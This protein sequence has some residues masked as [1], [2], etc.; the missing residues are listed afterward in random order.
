[1]SDMLMIGSTATSAFRRALEVT[2]HNVANVSTEGYSRQRAE[3]VNNSA[4]IVGPVQ[5]GG[6]V[7]VDNVLRIQADYIQS[8]LVSSSST[9]SRYDESLQQSKQVEGLIAGNDEGVQQV[10]QQ[11][12]D[13]I[14]N[15]ASNPT[16]NVNRQLVVD[17][18]SKLESH[19]ENLTSVLISNEDDVNN[20]IDSMVLE[21]NARVDLVA[22]VNDEVGKTL[23]NGGQLPNDL[24]DQ[25]DQAILEL[26][27]LIDIKAHETENGSIDIYTA[28]GKFPLVSD[29]TV[30]RIDSRLSEF[31]NENRKEVY[32]TISGQSRD[33]GEFITGGTLGGILDFRSEMLDSAKN[34]LGVMLNGLVASTNWQNYQGYDVNGDAG[35]EIFTPLAVSGTKSINNATGSNDGSAILVQFNPTAPA[36]APNA[37]PYNPAGL[38]PLTYGDK[39]AYLAN[40]YDSMGNMKASEYIMTHDGANFLVTNRETN[41]LLGTVIP[42]TPVEIDGLEFSVPAPPAAIYQAGDSFVIKPHQ[43]ILKQ[44]EVSLDDPD[45]IAARGQS[46]ADTNADG[47]ILDEVPTAGAQG[48]N[49]NAAN[50]ANLGS[51]KILYSDALN[52]PT[53]TLLGGYSIMATGIGMYVQSSDIKLQAQTAVYENVL[54]RR[55]SFSGVSLDEEAANLVRFQQAYEAAAQVISTSKSIFDTLLSAVRG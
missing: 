4:Q 10:L 42:G 47:S 38:Q 7:R 44:F 23:N 33:I 5:K 9:K 3:F 34:E 36:G 40:A 2:G 51:K 41:A 45:K 50:L 26:S 29:G 43:A 54:D 52:Q 19:I 32:M 49:V 31:S 24:L 35:E 46:P 8:Q 37:P 12:F 17:E 15:L 39:E 28:S 53:E 6:G 11:F 16:S 1:M 13:S 20:Q 22:R 21:I 25:R 14:Q 48:D 30:T 27:Q 55:E 18:A